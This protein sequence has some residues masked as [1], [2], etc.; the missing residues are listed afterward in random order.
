VAS[1]CWPAASAIYSAT[2]DCSSAAPAFTIASLICG[3]STTQGML[4]AARAVQGL[5]GAVVSAVAFSAIV[6]LFSEPLHSPAGA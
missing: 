3:V 5:G 1:F 2:G 6:V 4:I